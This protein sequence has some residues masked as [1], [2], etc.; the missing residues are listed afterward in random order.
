MVEATF[1][2]SHCWIYFQL[3]GLHIDACTPVQYI[4][5]LTL[6]TRELE[7]KT[8]A[9]DVPMVSAKY[10]LVKT[11]F[12]SSTYHKSAG[13]RRLLHAFVVPSI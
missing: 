13:N 11:S 6:E 5:V 4:N 10:H 7:A 8:R 2:R 12:L 9:E 1:G 3:A